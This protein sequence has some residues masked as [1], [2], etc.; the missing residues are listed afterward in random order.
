VSVR[1][2]FTEPAAEIAREILYR[3]EEVDF[4]A[5]LLGKPAPETDVD[6]T[7]EHDADGSCLSM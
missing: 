6:D 4:A 5:A 3:L 2:R 7:M 1:D